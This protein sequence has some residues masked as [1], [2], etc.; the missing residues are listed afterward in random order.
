MSLC[1]TVGYK[2]VTVMNGVKFE[3]NYRAE[4]FNGTFKTVHTVYI[5]PHIVYE[6]RF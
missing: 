4:I 5:I 2:I 6:K 3:L 1:F